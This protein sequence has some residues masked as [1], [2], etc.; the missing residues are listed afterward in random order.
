VCV[1]GMFTVVLRCVGNANKRVF[2]TQ[3]EGF[4][5]AKTPIG[6]FA[7]IEIPNDLYEVDKAI[8]SYYNLNA[9]PAPVQEA[10]KDAA[11]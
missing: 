6:M 4:D 5:V 1:E 2:M 10:K 11:V 8:R 7:D 9:K 3:S